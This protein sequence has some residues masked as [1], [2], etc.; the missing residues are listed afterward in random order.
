MA[1]KEV[2]EGAQI[3]LETAVEVAEGKTDLKVVKKS[4]KQKATKN[5]MQEFQD[6][7]EVKKLVKEMRE[8]R[9]S[10]IEAKIQEEFTP[11]DW[12]KFKTFK[13]LHEYLFTKGRLE[14]IE[15]GDHYDNAWFGVKIYGDEH[16]WTE[17]DTKTY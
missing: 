9:Q 10:I 3:D 11:E 2:E 16:K 4:K 12:E 6:D 8:R 17:K 1:K 15:G 5:P 14:I 7:E 13:E